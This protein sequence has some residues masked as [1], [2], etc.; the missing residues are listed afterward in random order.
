MS[1]TTKNHDKNSEEIDRFNKFY[2]SVDEFAQPIVDMIT[3]KAAEIEDIDHGLS[4][5]AV[6]CGLVIKHV[7]TMNPGAKDPWG[8]LAG[9]YVHWTSSQL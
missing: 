3:S 4:I 5:L 1:E 6:V 2:E 9:N 8:E 7:K